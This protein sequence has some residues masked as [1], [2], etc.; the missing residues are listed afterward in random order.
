MVSKKLNKTQELKFIQHI[1][2][3]SLILLSFPLSGQEELLNWM[4]PLT[5]ELTTETDLCE[6]CTWQ[7]PAITRVVFNEEFFYFLRYSCSI[8]D[9]FA[10]MYDGTGEIVGEC[11]TINGNSDCGFGFNAFSIYTLAQTIVPIWSCEKSFDCDFAD[12]NNL[13]QEVPITIDDS[14]CAEGVKILKV[15]NEFEEYNW[16]ETE[17]TT[18]S[19]EVTEA[20]RYEVTVTDRDGCTKTGAI[21][22]EEIEALEV[23]IKGPTQICPNSEATLTATPSQSFQ[24]SN[25]MTNSAITINQAGMYSVSVTNEADCSGTTS[26]MVD[27]FDLPDISIE[28]SSRTIKEGEELD[29]SL[30]S[31]DELNTITSQEWEGEGIFGCQ[32]CVETT[33]RPI[34][35]GNIQVIIIDNRGCQSSTQLFIEVEEQPLEVYAPNIFAPE[36]SGA[37]TTF[38]LYSGTNVLEIQ[39]LVIF[40]RWGNLIFENKNFQP[41]QT[42]VGWDGTTNGQLVNQDVYLYKADVLFTNGNLKTFTG[43]VLVI[44]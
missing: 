31:T 44:Y 10:R 37:N 6:R 22:V 17:T 18:N 29:L 4:I 16:S 25:G 39:E 23:A 11:S 35:S 15:A 14:R 24:W 12:T 42:S 19:I 30:I 1:L 5:E 36:G 43:D 7:S 20:G 13:A 40:D 27:E 2:F 41:N 32:D 38:T 26:F 8:E 3:T 21:S 34:A 28:T 9:N 33:F